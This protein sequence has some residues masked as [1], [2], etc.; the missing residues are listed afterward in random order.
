MPS[1]RSQIQLPISRVAMVVFLA[2]SLLPLVP[3]QAQQPPPAQPQL[4]S[5]DVND[6][7]LQNFVAAF[8]EVE[9]I[10][11][12][13]GKK[14][15]NVQ[16]SEAATRLQ[17]EANKE[18]IAAVQENDLKPQRYNALSNAVSNDKQLMQRF[19]EVRKERAEEQDQ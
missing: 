15:A 5:A 3:A 14:M 7:D 11:M 1:P 6:E 18:M 9:V 13:L 16:D 10:R 4:T 2:A 8:E 19:Q 17:Q 12:E